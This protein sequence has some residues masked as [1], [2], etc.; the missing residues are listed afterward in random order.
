[1][2]TIEKVSKSLGD[3]SVVSN[4]SFDFDGKVL[5]LTGKNGVGKTTLLK[6]LAG[7]LDADSGQIIYAHSGIYANGGQTP[8]GS[9]VS[10]APS[11]LSFG[12]NL[13]PRFFIQ[14]LMQAKADGL[15]A[16]QLDQLWEDWLIP[17]HARCVHDL[18]FGNIQKLNLIQALHSKAQVCIF[19]EPT[20]GLDAEGKALFLSHLELIND[21]LIIICSHD[22]DTLHKM[23]GTVYTL[24]QE[25]DGSTLKPTVWEASYTIIY[26]YSGERASINIPA[27]EL[28]ATLHRLSRDA[29]IED[30]IKLPFGTQM[31]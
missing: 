31:T 17:P 3:K 15:N 25:S 8:R 18:S 9:R 19:D 22:I 16:R 30:V 11:R 4:L 21:A 10:Y 20:N 24:A 14:T 26:V 29:S 13:P 28:D 1:M 23:S 2:L 27:P 7:L 12:L 5:T 6:L